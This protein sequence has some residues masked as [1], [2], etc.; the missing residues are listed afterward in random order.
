MS[1]ASETIS[2]D[3]LNRAKVNGLAGKKLLRGGINEAG[4]FLDKSQFTPAFDPCSSMKVLKAY[5]NHVRSI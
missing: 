2:F 5:N 4:F 1:E 3:M